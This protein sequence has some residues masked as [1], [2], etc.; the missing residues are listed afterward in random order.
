MSRPEASGAGVVRI[1]ARAVGDDEDALPFEHALALARSND[2]RLHLKVK[3]HLT[4]HNHERFCGKDLK[5]AFLL[6]L[7]GSCP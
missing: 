6:P 1:R 5:V 3:I 4:Q 2:D 7:S